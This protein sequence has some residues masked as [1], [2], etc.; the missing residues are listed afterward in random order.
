MATYVR[1]G[2][3]RQVNGVYVYAI[4]S[5]GNNPSWR[6]VNSAWVYTGSGPGGGWK[7]VHSTGTFQPEIRDAGG[8]ALSYRNVGI[9]MV[10]YRGY[11]ASGTATYQWQYSLDGGTGWSNQTGT[12][13][14]GSYAATTLTTSYTTDVSDVN[15]IETVSYTH[16][17]LPTIL[18]V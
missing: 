2:T 11:T 8:T 6:T 17:T 18:R 16:L 9:S 10:G 3:W 1:D 12:N 15:S 14:S 4:P 5:G 7:Q 13:N